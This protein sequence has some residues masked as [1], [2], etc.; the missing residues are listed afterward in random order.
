MWPPVLSWPSIQDVCPIAHYSGASLALY[1]AVLTGRVVSKMYMLAAS[2]HHFSLLYYLYFPLRSA[3][4]DP[5]DLS[6]HSLRLAGMEGG[7]REG[8]RR[9]PSTTLRFVL[10]VDA[11]SSVEESRSAR[12]PCRSLNLGRR[13]KDLSIAGVQASANHEAS[14]VP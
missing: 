11:A 10:E 5:L 3:S 13:F 9:C 12:R 14:T 2:V 6:Y 4:T 8:A 1:I 7:G